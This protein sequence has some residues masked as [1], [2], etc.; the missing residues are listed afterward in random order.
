MHSTLRLASLA[1]FAAACARTVVPVDSDAA[2]DAPANLACDAAAPLGTVRWRTPIGH[3]RFLVGPMAAD[4]AGNTYFVHDSTLLGVADPEPFIVSLD[5]CGAMR[6]RAPWQHPNNR[7]VLP[8]VTLA[9]SRILAAN[10][11]LHAFDATSGAAQWTLDLVAFAARE[12][13]GDVSG[14]N[15]IRSV[16]VDAS[17][18][19]FVMLW[20][21]DTISIVRVDPNGTPRTLTRITDVPRNGEATD[22]V[23]DAQG[24]FEAAFTDTNVTP[25]PGALRS[26]G[27]DGA[28]RWITHTPALGYLDHLTVGSNFVVSGDTGTIFSTIDGSIV[29]ELGVQYAG[30]GGTDAADNL[31]V[32][33]NAPSSGRGRLASFDRAGTRRWTSTIEGYLAFAH[34]AGP[35][36]GEH[37]GFYV[38]DGFDTQRDGGTLARQVLVA[39]DLASGT[40]SVFT[41]PGAGSGHALLTTAGMV[42]VVGGDAVAISSGGEVPDASG[43]WVTPRGDIDRRGAARGR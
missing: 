8:H 7:S 30:P 42:F 20:S 40:Q 35:L 24:N 12:G 33:D 21:P 14:S 38:F 23:L 41:Y 25:G 31:Y 6:W 3:D 15:A 19:A 32:F 16:V 18:N 1:L 26:F 28:Q 4:P 29:R 11:D 39:F 37:T 43:T 22:L 27:P 5:R 17:G 34:D 9:G 13:L 36:L 2:T 10:V